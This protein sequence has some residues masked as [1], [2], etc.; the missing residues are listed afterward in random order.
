MVRTRR[1]RHPATTVVVVLVVAV[2][3][4]G[5]HGAPPAAAAPKPATKAAIAPCTLLKAAEVSAR[6]DGAT[7]G[8][9]TPGA[10]TA[11][12]VECTWPVAAGPALPAGTV[13]ARVMTVGAKAAY[14]GLEQMAGLTRV[15]D[16]RNTLAMPSTG[17]VMT[18]TGSRL[19]TVQ[20]VFLTGVPVRA[21][22]VQDRLLPLLAD[23]VKRV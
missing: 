14:R 5:A 2:G 16:R 18:L 10:T 21:V 13:S 6:F 12:S 1:H 19:V 3:A 22:D 9:P 20:G 4:L 11:V 8:V 23:A 7:V 17:A 15:A